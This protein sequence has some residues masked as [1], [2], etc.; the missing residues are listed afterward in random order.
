VPLIGAQLVHLLL[1][2]PIIAGETLSRFF[3]LHVFII[4]ALII[5]IVSMHLRLVLTK[6]IN[7]Y[8]RPGHPVRKSTYDAEYAEILRK[9]GVPFVPH[10]IG[11]D[12]IFSGLVIVGI[13]GCA[14]F[15]GPKG[16]LGEPNPTIVDTNPRPDFY[17]LSIFAALALLPDWMEVLVLFVAPTIA[18]LFLLCLPFISG[19]GEK[20]CHRYF[21]LYGRNVAVVAVY[22]CLERRPCP[23]GVSSRA[24]S[25]RDARCAGISA[26]TMQELSRARRK[27]RRARAHVGRRCNAAH[28]RSAGKAGDPGRGQH[29]RLRPKVNS[30]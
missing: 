23:C 4:P 18:I 16:P 27:R 3:T 20:S 5:A 19:K 14:F 25:A 10:A 30:R 13:L 7:E 6:G 29:A 21:G 15:L 24:H 28:Q 22:V 26:Q 17:F 11:K 8:P 1:A 12:L 2:G 9:E